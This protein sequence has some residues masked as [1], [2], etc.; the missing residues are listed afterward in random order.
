MGKL[1]R[2]TDLHEEAPFYVCR[3]TNAKLLHTPK[4]PKLVVTFE[5]D[6]LL[7]PRPLDKNNHSL[8]PWIIELTSGGNQHAEFLK[9]AFADFEKGRDVVLADEEHPVRWL[10]SGALLILKD[11]SGEYAVINKR[12]GSFIWENRFDAN[13]GLASSIK[14]MLYPRELGV[15]ELKEEVKITARSGVGINPKLREIKPKNSYDVEV[16]FKGQVFETE[17][18]IFVPDAK[19]GT[20]DFRSIYSAEVSDVRKLVLSDMETIVS[21]NGKNLPT[22]RPILIFKLKDLIKMYRGSSI[23]RPVAGFINGQKIKPSELANY[24]VKKGLLTPVLGGILNAL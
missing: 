10:G 16:H 23:A 22:S 20:L 17:G 19:A 8:N 4:N 3:L 12:T 11:K 18:L 24:R 5:R 21:K 7:D 1:E 15:R 2:V 13:G 6:Q 14:D 9:E